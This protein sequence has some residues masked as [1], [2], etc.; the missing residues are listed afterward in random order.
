MVLAREEKRL[1]GEVEAAAAAT[2]R[3]RA[4]LRQVGALR[5]C[6]VSCVVNMGKWVL[7]QHPR[8]AKFKQAMLPNPK[9]QLHDCALPTLT[10]H[11]CLVCLLEGCSR[12][13]LAQCC[14]RAQQHP[15][16][17]CSVEACVHPC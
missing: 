16:M 7:L 9:Q 17:S 3:V 1:Q 4:V 15:L 12:C 2:E 11:C 6:D 10:L 5:A 14:G 8:D 13:Y